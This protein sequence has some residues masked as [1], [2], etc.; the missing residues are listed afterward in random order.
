MK[1]ILAVVALSLMPYGVAVAGYDP[2]LNC[3]ALHPEPSKINPSRAVFRLEVLEAAGFGEKPDSRLGTGL[4]I[5]KSKGLIV[6]SYHVVHGSDPSL[7]TEECK[8]D[9]S[10]I[11]NIEISTN[12]FGIDTAIPVQHLASFAC[13]DSV[14]L[15][16]DPRYVTTSKVPDFSFRML[17]RKFRTELRAMNVVASKNPPENPWALASKFSYSYEN[18]IKSSPAA[19]C[20]NHRCLKFSGQSVPNGFSGGPVFDEDGVVHGIIVKRG[21]NSK[22]IGWAVPISLIW[23]DIKK[24]YSVDGDKI[25]SIL[26]WASNPVS[27]DHLKD[28]NQVSS[29][30][31]AW[32]FSKII[33]EN[34]NFDVERNIAGCPLAVVADHRDLPVEIYNHFWIL[35]K[36]FAESK[37]FNSIETLK[38]QRGVLRREGQVFL[39][40]ANAAA[41]KGAYREAEENASLAAGLFELSIRGYSATENGPGYIFAASTA[42]DNN[43]V[44]SEITGQLANAL[45]VQDWE[46]ASIIKNDVFSSL[47]LE[48]ADAN[49]LSAR[50]S[51]T[52][53]R[54]DRL[55]LA[56]GASNWA[57]AAANS[58]QMEVRSYKRYGDSL[59][60]A[61]RTE[62]AQR[63]YAKALSA[64]SDN[65][66]S[67]RVFLRY[68]E[69]SNELGADIPASVAAARKDIR[70]IQGVQTNASKRIEINKTAIDRAIRRS[71]AK[72]FRW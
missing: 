55:T 9:T 22:D 10:S 21:E 15:R 35:G 29:Q 63:A 36:S 27:M 33:A 67:E 1:K 34:D 12:V 44:G 70:V 52:S 23:E 11:S 24:F 48:Y 47:L 31:L 14:L 6:S 68:F 45:E 16:I 50:F 51:V 28:R 71:L 41:N 37:D 72:P 42:L 69:T 3:S 65:E 62:D 17:N 13:S 2:A 59:R 7:D 43:E 53:T 38:Q 58:E 57:A 20:S 66:E 49:I 64:S 5:D 8:N 26:N 61:E 40:S 39:A 32:S 18:K 60:A 56:S 46:N 30:E 19:I 54:N 25:E 4:L